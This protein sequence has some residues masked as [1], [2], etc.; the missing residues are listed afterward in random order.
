MNSTSNS[1]SPIEVAQLILCILGLISGL[2]GVITLTP[3]VCL[4]GL[5]LL[6]S[7][8]GCFALQQALAD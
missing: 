1:V 4:L 6:L 8:L 7:G 2:I 3:A 5:F